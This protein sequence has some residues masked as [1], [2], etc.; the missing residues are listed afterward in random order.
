MTDRVSNTFLH[1]LRSATIGTVQ[2]KNRLI[3]PAMETNFGSSDGF[4]TEQTKAYYRDRAKGGVGLVTVEA[5]T[6]DYPS[7][8][9]NPYDLSISDDRYI[10][11]LAHLAEKIQK[12]G[13]KAAIQLHHAGGETWSSITYAPTLAPSALAG[14][15]QEKPRELTIREIKTIANKFAQGALRAKKAGFNG[16]EIHSAHRSLLAHFLSPAWNKRSDIYGGSLVNRAHFLLE[17]LQRIR[18]RMGRDYPVWVKINGA[19]YGLE[20]GLTLEEAQELSGLIEENEGDAILVSSFGIGLASLR[21]P[22][23]YEKGC[24]IPLAESIKKVV[25]IPVIGVGRITPEQGE[26]AIKEG[27]IDMVAMG[28][29]LI[30]D[31]YLPMKIAQGKIEEIRPCIACNHC[32]EE[33]V[34]KKIPITCSV[35]PAVGREA[36]WWSKKTE[37][38]KKVLVIGG[39]V[40]GLEASCTAAER[41][42]KVTL[43]EKGDK[44]GGKLLAA[45]IPPTKD[46]INEFTGYMIRR[47][48]RA[49]VDIK[50]NIEVSLEKVRELNPEVIIIAIGALPNVPSI[51]GLKDYVLAPDILLGRFPVG[52]KAVIIGGGMVGC[53]TADWLS[54]QGKEVTVIE[55]LPRLAT[56]MMPINRILLLERLAQKRVRTLTEVMIE[57]ISANKEVTFCKKGQQETIKVDTIILA[58]GYKVIRDE[59]CHLSDKEVYLIGDF[60]YPRKIVDSV[61]EGSEIG[62]NI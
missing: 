59:L 52:K 22:S 31:P 40:A 46:D 29:A 53:E 5:T 16:I 42:H 61:R 54:D 3:L 30:S 11:G 47:I 60:L 2:V 45:A 38:P 48:I 33:L 4:V 41:G 51:T 19:E 24:L 32:I 20:R 1:L 7:G 58:T 34:F 56:D 35:N 21:G 26:R 44:L 15:S 9:A 57:N 17:I 27:K 6:V 39:G 50:T 12:N 28:R 18:D 14:C 23:V 49:G 25:N 36:W 43:C 37:K 62:R 13:A 10:P 55:I 8:K